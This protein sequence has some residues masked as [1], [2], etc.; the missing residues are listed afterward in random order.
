MRRPSPRSIVLLVSW[1]LLTFQPAIR[2]AEPASAASES[3][4][5]RRLFDYAWEEKI[6]QNPDFAAYIG[7]PERHDRWTDYSQAAIERRHAKAREQ[8]KELLSIDRVRLTPPERTDLDLF[9]RRLESQIDGFRFPLDEMV[10]T[11]YDGFQQFV[12]RLAL[13]PRTSTITRIFWRG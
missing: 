9:R 13:P 11:R 7:F 4:R 5:L 1:G 12:P 2:A 3:V 6:R 8:L 10:L